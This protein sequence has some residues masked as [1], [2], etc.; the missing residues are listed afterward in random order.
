MLLSVASR[1]PALWMHEFLLN[2]M[3]G[4][5]TEHASDAP[6][7]RATGLER[8]YGANGTRQQLSV[9]AHE[10]IRSFQIDTL[11]A[12]ARAKAPI[13]T[14]IRSMRTLRFLLI[15]RLADW[16]P[17]AAATSCACPSTLPRRRCMRPSPKAWPPELL[18]DW[19]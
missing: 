15:T 17:S 6:F 4:I 1:I 18:S 13:R 7:R 14:W 3:T 10:L 12:R 5:G 2:F 9:L 16:P 11:A 19:S 8:N